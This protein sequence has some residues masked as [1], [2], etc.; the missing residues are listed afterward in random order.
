MKKVTIITKNKL[1]TIGWVTG[2]SKGER[3]VTFECGNRVVVLEV[4][5]DRMVRVVV[6]PHGSPATFSY[7]VVSS[8]SSWPRCAFTLEEREHEFSL[9]TAALDVRVKKTPFS[10]IFCD[11]DGQVLNA[12]REGFA[13]AWKDSH[14]RCYKQMREGERFFGFGEKAGPLDK[15][16]GAM[17]MW[18]RETL[19]R[20]TNIDP[21]YQSIPFFIGV[22]GG[23]AYGI[24]FDNTHRGYF[25]MGRENPHEYSFGA[26]GG[27]L[28]YYFIYGP[29]LGSILN[30]Y[31]RLTGRMPLPPKWALGYHQSRYSYHTE[32]KVRRIAGKFRRRGIPCDAIHLDSHYMDGFRSF[33]FDRQRFP[34][35]GRL[36]ADLRQQGFHVV[37]V[38]DPG[39]KIDEDFPIYRECIEHGFYCRKAD[40]TPFVGLGWPGRIIF[41]DFTRK[42][43]KEWWVDLHT[44]YFDLGIEGIWNDMNEPS[45][46]INPRT[47]GLWQWLIDESDMY[48]DDQGLNS[49]VAKVRNVYALNECEATFQ[50]F[51]KHRPHWRPFILTRSGYA[52]IQRYAAT[53]TG[54]NWSSF[55]HIGLSVRMQLNMGLSGVPFTG[56]DI[57]GFMGIRKMFCQDPRLYARWIQVGVFYPF[58]R[59]HTAIY[60]RPQEPWSFGRRVEEISRRYITLRYRLL[61]YIY[62]LFREAATGGVPIIRP[63]FFNHQA[64]EHCYDPRFENQFFLGRDLLIVPIT[65]KKCERVAVYLP[66]GEW[67]HFWSGEEFAGGKEYQVAVG[68]DDI[69]VFVRRGA[70]LPMQPPMQ[71]VGEKRIDVLT[72]QVYPA[73]S[74]SLELYEDDGL[75]QDYRSGDY[76]ITR[77]ECSATDGEVRIS[78]GDRD[79]SFRP[80]YTHFLFRV[81]LPRQPREV[82]V[83]GRTVEQWTYDERSRFL[84]FRCDVG[85][86]EIWLSIHT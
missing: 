10:L 58:C 53:W 52:G 12:D 79:G 38:V 54:D 17:V 46:N 48:M 77:F 28:D 72:L 37:T 8:L 68:L 39:V 4:F 16:G 45:L 51:R 9:R 26:D 30:L 73:K 1:E 80:E 36:V 6:A 14:V 57:G 55:A 66:A 43:V 86:R 19:Y 2:Y 15:R 67:I 20:S 44:F 60:T 70:I 84:E 23:T 56:A 65:E 5:D 85:S 49:N 63:L 75:T 69:P 29:D 74:G 18:A 64:D 25:D 81:F 40:G 59:T 71:Y 50:A 47:L 13:C 78:T 41:P 24:F 62:N 76:C 83:D 35:P 42:D 61:P 22:S 31:T 3:G 34:D 7:A 11:R 27:A 32:E 21:L 82:T 33:T